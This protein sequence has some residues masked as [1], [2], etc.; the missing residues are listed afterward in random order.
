MPTENV[1]LPN[2]PVLANRCDQNYLTLN[3]GSFCD[4]RIDRIDL[5]PHS[6]PPLRASCN[7]NNLHCPSIW[8]ACRT[9]PGSRLC[10]R[11]N[12]FIAEDEIKG[13]NN[14]DSCGLSVPDKWLEL[15]FLH[16][17][18]GRLSQVRISADD[19]LAVG[20]PGF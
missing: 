12:R 9:T 11:I 3:M 5:L 15:P 8:E 7:P 13:K 20:I 6:F 4:V 16:R 1:K 18:N 19:S 10:I 14:G 2:V 17:I